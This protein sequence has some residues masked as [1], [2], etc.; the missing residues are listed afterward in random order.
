[1]RSFL[2]GRPEHAGGLPIKQRK[3]PESN[4]AGQSH[5]ASSAGLSVPSD[6]VSAALADLAAVC[7]LLHEQ[8]AGSVDGLLTG[9]RAAL[10]A[11][12]N[13]DHVTR[14]LSGAI[15]DR[16]SADAPKHIDQSGCDMP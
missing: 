9:V 15:T 6:R 1:M 2:S 12:A 11:G 16:A 7:R 3:V 13:I 4:R 8:D 10:S 14:L 5:Q